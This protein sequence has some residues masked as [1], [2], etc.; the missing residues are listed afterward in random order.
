[1]RELPEISRSSPKFVIVLLVVSLLAQT[2]G[3]IYFINVGNGHGIRAALFQI[4]E[5]TD[6]VDLN[7]NPENAPEWY[8]SD[9]TELFEDFSHE[10]EVVTRR[11]A[12][13]FGKYV[14]LMSYTRNLGRETSREEVIDSDSVWEV[15]ELLKQGFKGNCAH[16]SWLLMA[17]LQSIGK[18]ARVVGLGRDRLSTSTHAVVEVWVESLKKWATLDAMY[19]AYFSLHG[20]P[21]SLMEIRG[22]LY[23]GDRDLVE[24]H[25]DSRFDIP[26]VGLV[27]VYETQA[28][29]ISIDGM[30]NVITRYDRRYG[31]LNI[32]APLFDH[33]PRRVRRVI[34]N[35][36][37][38]GDLRFHFV[39]GHTISFQATIYRT[40]FW[41]LVGGIL[42]T[43]LCII[44]HSW[45]SR[46]RLFRLVN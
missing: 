8:K 40:I 18:N 9:S 29:D 34:D 31:V 42:T 28:K 14:A 17:Y 36:F 1:M 11:A 5:T 32:L 10:A 33:L 7:W 2:W 38:E 15:R 39:D 27:H 23:S 16:Y 30:G 37:G 4:I 3:L 46:F 13:E 22:L 20:V 25:Q 21:L 45:S 41:F 26:K 35:I 44:W 43:L 12:T 6:P 24:V 19:G